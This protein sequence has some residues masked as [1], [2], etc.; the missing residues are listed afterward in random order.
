MWCSDAKA[1]FGDN[2]A[3]PTKFA[4]I[5]TIAAQK[6]S[7]RSGSESRGWRVGFKML[8]LLTRRIGR[9]STWLGGARQRNERLSLPRD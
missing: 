7:Q 5:Q 9:P 6:A 8:M 4:V 1:A 2:A 3:I